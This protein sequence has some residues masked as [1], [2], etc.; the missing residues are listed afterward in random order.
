MFLNKN[1]R[2]IFLPIVS[3]VYKKNN[4]ILLNNLYKETTF[5]INII[6][7]PISII[8]IFFSSNIIDLFDKSEFAINYIHL[9]HILIFTKI[10]SLLFGN[11]GV[12]M[13]MAGFE[14]NDVYI[15][16]V[17]T[18]FSILF[19]IILIKQYQ[20][21]AIVF[22]FMISSIG[23]NLFQFLILNKHLKLNPFSKELFFLILL[24]IVIISIYYIFNFSMRIIFIFPFSMLIF[25]IYYISF[26]NKISD[27]IKKSKK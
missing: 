26:R 8:I 9:L 12:Y 24:T 4:V 15:Q 5:I 23:V 27:L 1:L 19:S 6:S 17:K 14:K 13:L 7:I 20:L 25:S 16:F 2:N 3:K 18:I 21:E 22:I 11:T 10:I